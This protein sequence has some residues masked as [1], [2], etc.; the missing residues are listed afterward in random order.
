MTKFK[1]IIALSITILIIL[2]YLFQAREK[3]TWPFNTS[4]G[5]YVPNQ[6]KSL[7]YK[8]LTSKNYSI[9]SDKHNLEITSISIPNYNFKKNM[10]EV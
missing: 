9:T 6:A 10:V 3:N 5:Y 1:Y 4:F 2:I 8:I 7:I